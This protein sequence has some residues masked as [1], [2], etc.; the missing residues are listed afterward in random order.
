MS[1]PPEHQPETIL[2]AA[3]AAFLETGVQTSTA[4]VASRAGVSNGTLFNYFPTKQALIDRLYLWIKA[5]L[6]EAIGE[7]DDAQ[8]IRDQM[9]EVWDRWLAWARHHRDAYS[10]MNLLHQSGLA[11]EEARVAG[12]DL[13]RIPMRVL[14][15]AHETGALV[16]LPLSYLAALVQHQLDQAVMA[17][18]N[19]E[20]SDTAFGVLW[21]GITESSFAGR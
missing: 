4:S 18:L 11:S 6:A 3:L 2:T 13:I 15:D 12:L 8:P 16:D 7:L 1:R 20:E 14:A 5:D 10:V 21:N 17:D 9:N 19:G